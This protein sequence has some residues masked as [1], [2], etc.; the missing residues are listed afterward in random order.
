[1]LTLEQIAE[2]E[3][4]PRGIREDCIV[5]LCR[6]ARIGAREEKAQRY[7]IVAYEADDMESFARADGEWLFADDV[8]DGS[9]KQ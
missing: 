9:D 2:I 6:L 5:E 1:M 8:L 4:L 3:R 7:A